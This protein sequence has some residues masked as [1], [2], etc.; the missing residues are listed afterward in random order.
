VAQPVTGALLAWH[1]G[2]SLSESWSAASI[3]LYI[4]TGGFWLP[5]V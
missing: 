1:M 3:S 5:V 4:V 2:F